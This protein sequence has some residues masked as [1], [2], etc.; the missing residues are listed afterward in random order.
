MMERVSTTQEM[1]RFLMGELRVRAGP[2]TAPPG[3]PGFVA[4]GGSSRGRHRVSLSRDLYRQVSSSIRRCLD[5]RAVGV[6]LASWMIRAGPKRS[7]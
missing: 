3:A 6:H 7:N 4:G 2:A 5:R 1:V